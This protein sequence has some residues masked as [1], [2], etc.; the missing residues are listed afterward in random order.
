M[1]FNASIINNKIKF[2]N[3][4]IV[5]EYIQTLENKKIVITIEKKVKKRTTGKEGELGNQ[6]GWYWKIIIP[7]CS[8]ELGYSNKEMHEIFISEFA[9]YKVK[10]LGNKYIKLPIRTSEMN[11]IQF[12]EYCELIKIKMAELNIFFPNPI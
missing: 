12:T 6:N 11:T 10:K 3:I 4:Q 9:P 1:Q 8:K 2:D 5:R 7:I